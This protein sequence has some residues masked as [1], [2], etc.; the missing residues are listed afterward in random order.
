MMEEWEAVF[1][2]VRKIV[3]SGQPLPESLARVREF[4]QNNP[5]L[6]DEPQFW[7]QV[8]QHDFR[9]DL[10]LMADW[11]QQGFEVLGTK[12][13]WE[14]LLLD[15]GDC[16]ETF[17]LY[18]PG[19]QELMSEHLFR[20]NLLRNLIIGPSNMEDCFSSEVTNPFDQLFTARTELCDHHVS[21]IPNS[22]LDWTGNSSMD[23]HGNSGYLLWLT[24]GTLSLTEPLRDEVYCQAILRGRDKLY[25]FSGYEEIFSYVATVT[26]EGV[27]YET[28]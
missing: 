17:R 2:E 27:L 16:P 7:Q 15:L 13:G 23:F 28:A 11:A 26:P 18:R 9:A 24:L 12:E 3:R 6:F 8:Q 22:L 10:E 4:A 1:R 5:A 21:E 14:F 20:A 25:L 19:G